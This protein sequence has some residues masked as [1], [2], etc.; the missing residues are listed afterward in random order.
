MY[1]VHDNEPEAH[2]TTCGLLSALKSNPRLATH[3]QNL[4]LTMDV[5]GPYRAYQHPKYDRRRDFLALC[6]FLP[7]PIELTLR[8]DHLSDDDGRPTTGNPHP[9]EM[10]ILLAPFCSSTVL[11][12]FKFSGDSF[13]FGLLM[14]APNLRHL[15]L[16]DVELSTLPRLEDGSTAKLPFRLKTAHFSRAHQPLFDLTSTNIQ[17][18]SELQSLKVTP[19]ITIEDSIPI[20]D[21]LSTSNGTL[22]EV[23]LPHRGIGRNSSFHSIWSIELICLTV[24]EVYASQD[25]RS[26][27]WMLNLR[28][29]SIDFTFW[30]DPNVRWTAVLDILEDI[31]TPL[32]FLEHLELKLKRVSIQEFK[33]FCDPM[34]R[35]WK[36]A[37]RLLSP[38]SAPL[39][40][41]LT[42]HVSWSMYFEHDERSPDDYPSMTVM[43]EMQEAFQIAF[44]TCIPV[45]AHDK[46]HV[47]RTF[48]AV[49]YDPDYEDSEVY[50]DDD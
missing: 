36:L 39:L 3:V 41:H 7:A 48:N 24:L 8:H 21:I 40:R 11:T 22:K 1:I 14:S 12:T 32:S 37:R 20:F 18:F 15:T 9:T 29:L 49:Y 31:R 43:N 34:N 5:N 45:Q 42:I 23:I 13:P 46:R 33:A 19:S 26:L 27:N 38:E 50:Y 44:E 30:E 47:R 25:H 10:A 4:F 28:R 17:I 2:K 35:G 6:Q 16:H